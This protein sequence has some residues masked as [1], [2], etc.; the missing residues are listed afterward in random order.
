MTSVC[1]TLSPEHLGLRH[2]TG[3]SGPKR[4]QLGEW[5]ITREVDG[6]LGDRREFSKFHS[7]S[8]RVIVVGKGLG[9][10]KLKAVGGGFGL[11]EVHPQ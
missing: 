9:A 5:F 6:I 11:G 8:L 7:G 1:F 4:S 10:S 3:N 2:R